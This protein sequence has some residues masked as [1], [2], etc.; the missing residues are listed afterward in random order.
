MDSAIPPHPRPSF[1]LSCSLSHPYSPTSRSREWFSLLY[2]HVSRPS[3]GLFTCPTGDSHTLQIDPSSYANPDHLSYFKFIGRVVGMAIFHQCFFGAFF[4][5][6]FY[7]AALRENATVTDLKDIDEAFCKGLT[8][9][10]FVLPFFCNPCADSSQSS[11]ENDI[12]N[13]LDETF[14]A[15]EDRFGE[16]ITVDFKPGG[17][18]IPVTEKNKR[19]FVDLVAHYRI[20]GRVEEQFSAFID[21]F[22]EVI[23]RTLLTEFY[24]RE[25]E[26]FFRG[27]TPPE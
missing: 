23:P 27:R 12:T 1:N 10:L 25:M 24:E 13:I 2:R 17:S 3:C 19:E 16:F 9:I 7:K 5:P 6:G 20:I 21:G 18:E 8:W 11:S 26:D 15:T 14:S 4:V 22:F